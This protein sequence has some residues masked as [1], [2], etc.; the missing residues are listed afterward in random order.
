MIDTIVLRIHDC[1]KYSHITKY[2]EKLDTQNYVKKFHHSELVSLDQS[3]VLYGDTGNILT[4]SHRSTIG[5]AS[6]HYNVVVQNNYRRNYIEINFSIPKYVFSNNVCQFIDQHDQSTKHTFDKLLNLLQR[7]FVEYFP[8]PP[9]WEDVEVNRIDFCFNQFFLSKGDALRYLDEQ[10]NLN[11][12][13]ARSDKNKFSEYHG[14]SVQYVTANYSFKIYH[15]GTEFKK[16]DYVKLLKNNPKGFDVPQLAD[17]A[18]KILRYELTA[19]KSLLNYI[20]KQKLKDDVNTVFNHHYGLIGQQRNRLCR[21]FVQDVL[22]NKSFSFHLTSQWED[23]FAPINKLVTDYALPFNEELFTA[24][25]TFFWE[26]VERYQ[27]GVKMGIKEIHDKIK[28]HKE[29]AEFKKKVFGDKQKVSQTGQL[30]MLATLSQYVDIS[31][32]KDVIPKATFYRYRKKLED[33]GIPRFSPDIAVAPP[34]LDYTSYFFY[35]SAHHT[36]FG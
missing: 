7:F 16:H 2:I 8:M 23:R 27:L 36:T 15:K 22:P 3:S 33:I 10:R 34:P 18:D 31:E 30:L 32:L 20:F 26:R 9:D 21:E 5:V 11:I 28:E 12:H 14:T 24:L 4:M 25:H 1:D 19:R 6:S 17:T 29:D 35:F 13:Q